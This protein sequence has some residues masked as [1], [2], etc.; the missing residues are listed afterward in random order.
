MPKGWEK[1]GIVPIYKQKGDTLDNGNF[2]AIKLLEHRKKMFE[3]VLER[4]LRKLITIN[5][6]QVGFS[7]RKGITDAVC[8]I[9]QLQEK[10]LEV[11]KDLFLTFVDLEKAYDKVPR[12]LVYWCLRRRGVP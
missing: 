12:D 3:K 1:S 4:I 2:R 6:M 7:P 5:N 8:I 11:H 9:L 10:H